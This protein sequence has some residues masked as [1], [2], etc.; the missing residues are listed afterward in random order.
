[1]METNEGNSGLQM[2]CPPLSHV[3]HTGVT[4][5]LGIG[6]DAAE[7]GLA[8][9]TLMHCVLADCMHKDEKEGQVH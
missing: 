9:T 5:A 3:T 8:G 6:A 2:Q 1:M 7:W 4:T